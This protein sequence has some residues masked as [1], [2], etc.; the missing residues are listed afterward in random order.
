MNAEQFIREKK[1]FINGI[2]LGVK[3]SGSQTICTAFEV[4]IYN[5]LLI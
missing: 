5:L 4:N 3:S 1:V 2:P